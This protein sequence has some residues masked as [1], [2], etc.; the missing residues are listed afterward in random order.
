MDR[1]KGLVRLHCDSLMIEAGPAVAT[2]PVMTTAIRYRY[3]DFRG[4]GS[5]GTRS[6]MPVYFYFIPVLY[7][8]LISYLD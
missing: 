7:M 1:G 6:V 3:H 4:L 5:W 8:V 2:C